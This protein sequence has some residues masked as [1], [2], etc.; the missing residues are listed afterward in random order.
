M[1]YWKAEEYQKFAFPASEYVLGDVL[2]EEEYHLW[3]LV[4]RITEIVFGYGRSGMTLSE[5]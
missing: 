2:A 3:V 1:G 5:H 4:V